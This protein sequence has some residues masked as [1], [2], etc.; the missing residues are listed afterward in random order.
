MQ[1]TSNNV[2]LSYNEQGQAEFTFTLTCSKQEA[3]SIFAELKGIL[4]KG[5]LLLL[6]IK[7]FFDKRSPDSNAYMWTICHK[8]AEKLTTPKS[9]VTKD[10]VYQEAIRKVG[11]FEI[12]PVKDEAVDRWIKNWGE[13]KV[14]WVCESLGTS[15]LEGY[16]NVRSYYGSSVY[17]TREMSVL[18]D[19]IVEEA[20]EQGIET[21]TSDQISEMNSK[22]GD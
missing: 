6:D 12:V 15:K 11:Q 7:K 18:I 20:K 21:M 5:K 9:P 8:I 16:T 17:N 1:S 22:W 19:Y 3:I 10:D 4:S 2:R 14:G 13:N